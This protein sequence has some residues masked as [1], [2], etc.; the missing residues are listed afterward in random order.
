[1]I[2][3]KGKNGGFC[4]GVARAVKQAKQLSGKGNYILGQIIHN[5]SVINELERTGIK[6][7]N[8]LNEA[9]F[10]AGDNLLIRTHGEGKETFDYAT[11]LGLNVI[12]CTC[13]F[14]KEIHDIVKKH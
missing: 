12:D 13:P 5:E 2:V 8:S 11:K 1:M 14:V 7:I 4:F 3:L 6:T 10:C 9:N